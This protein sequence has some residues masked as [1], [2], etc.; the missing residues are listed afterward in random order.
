MRICVGCLECSFVMW[1]RARGESF[2]PPLE[3]PVG[4]QF[5]ACARKQVVLRGIMRGSVDGAL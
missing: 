3:K 5:I 1:W 2:G 4:R